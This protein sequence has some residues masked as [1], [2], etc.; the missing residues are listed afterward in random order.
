MSKHNHFVIFLK[1]IN[2][3]INSLIEK[4][5][6]KLNSK[7]LINFA[8]SNK[9]F[10]AIVAT[11]ILFLSYLS[12][13]YIFN[14][15]EIKS[16]LENQLLKKFDINFKFSKN[17]EYNFLPRPNFSVENSI[18]FENRS[19]I[20]DIK[21]IKIYVSIKNLFSLKNIDIKNITL[22]NAN[23]NLNKKNS[24]F[25]IDLLNNDFYETS[26]IIKN[27]NIFFRNINKEVLFINKIINMKY[28][29]DSNQQKNIFHS[30]N[31]I[32][33][34][35]YELKSYKLEDKKIFTNINL[36]FLNLLIENKFDYSNIQKKGTT[37]LIFKKNKSIITY[38]LDENYFYFNFYDKLISPEFIY[39]GKV[40]FNPFFTNIDGK[41]NNF[42]LSYL[43]DPNKFFVQ[44]LKTNIFNNKN[45]NI[46]LVVN[47]NQ[48]NKLRSFIDFFLNLKIEEGLIDIDKTKF[49][50]NDYA[51]F[52]ILDSL[53]YVNKNKLIL[54]GK[55]LIDINH[56]NKIYKFLQLSKNLRP[57]L[58]NIELD[59]NYDFDEKILKLKNIKINNEINE[60]V[61]RVLND[62][63]FKT[64]EVQNKIFI[65]NL[66]KKAL[67]VYS[68]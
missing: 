42:D 27:S 58:N 1:K 15:I 52:E 47:S 10:L 45:L 39:K 67:T 59:F 18:I 5:L 64:D 35:P 4:Y 51:D 33:N 6:N 24:D 65:K 55:L 16:E 34:I 48:I 3:S 49:S 66:I 41:T 46:D 40:N 8:L 13:P 54:D 68:G 2:L 11:I 9:V 7:N 53:L 61:S 20:S 19:E 57:E 63:S 28:F 17:F 25:F 36:N 21:Q 60:K 22:E 43:F 50:W 12:I 26:F 23:F 32:F 38:E 29:Y 14:K 37:N 31:E 30:N 44:L 62:I 56:Y